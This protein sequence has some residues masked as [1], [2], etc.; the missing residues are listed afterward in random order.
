MAVTW[1]V[2]G[3]ALTI[4]AG[5]DSASAGDTVLV[6]PGTYYETLTMKSGTYVIAEA[7]SPESTVV[8]G[9]EMNAV[10]LFYSHSLTAYLEGFTITNGWSEYGGGIIVIDCNPHITDCRIVDN[11]AFGDGGGIFCDFAAGATFTGCVI[12]GNTCSGNGGA[13]MSKG[14]SNTTLENCTFYANGA[15]GSGVL[16]ID[17]S[18]VDIQNCILSYG[19]SGSAVYCSGTGSATISCSNVYGNVGGDWVDCIAGQNGI[20]GNFSANP[21]FCDAAAGDFHLYETSP[22]VNAPGCGLVGALDVGCRYPK[23]WIVP[24]DAPTIQAG[25]DSTIMADTVLVR[26]GTYHERISVK[27]GISL[28]SETGE[29]DCVTI[30]GDGLGTVVSCW[31][32][33]SDVIYIEGFTITGGAGYTGGGVACSSSR[34][35]M[36]DCI[37]TG[38]T[39]TADGGGISSW[40]S[41]GPLYM[42]RCEITNNYAGD[43]GGGICARYA[44]IGLAYCLVEGNTCA[45]PGGGL[46]TRNDDVNLYKSIVSNNTS[47]SGGGGGHFYDPHTFDCD[48]CTFYGNDAPLASGMFIGDIQYP[49]IDKTIIAFGTGGYAVHGDMVSSILITCSDVYGNEGGDYVQRLAG[50]DTTGNNIW[51]DPLFCDPDSGDFHLANA[52]PCIG[53][54][55]GQIGALGVGC[56][57]PLLRIQSIEDVGDDQGR[58]VRITWR[59]SSY[60]AQTD[61]LDVT[62]YEVYRRQDG[63]LGTGGTQVSPGQIPVLKALGWDYLATVPA[64]GDSYYQYVA[65]T[66]CDSTASGICWSAFFI[67]AATSDPFEYRDSAPDSGYS[68]D[69]LAPTAPPGLIMNSATELAW[70]EV[71]DDDFDYY[72]VYGSALDALDESATLIG[73]TIDLSKDITDHVYEYYH[74]TATDFSGNEGEESSVNNVFAGVPQIRD[75]P[76]AFAL[77][78][79]RPNPFS[80]TTVIGFDLPEETGARIRIYDTH[81]RI[82][83]RLTDSNYEAGRHAVTWRGEDQ[84]GNQVSPGVYFIRMEAGEFEAMKKV[85]LLR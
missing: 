19:T 54:T 47:A 28:I 82:I 34:V 71:P 59:R 74:V 53:G 41:S 49:M 50:K 6:Y 31:F 16:S 4:Q 9:V 36:Y 73:Y 37:I 11:Y 69:N 12:A 70:E 77:R 55:C 76:T 30:D 25:I 57:D 10:V 58:N 63:Q 64:H 8:D 81:G 13:L 56:E 29:A 46:R 62:G 14:V 35:I 68:V 26:C 40:G 44:N 7:G 60:D 78:Q 38:N 52:S 33:H 79:N 84:A 51:A 65:S 32:A 20:N 2:P 80:T 1:E 83:I 42:E 17:S 48:Y 66:L 67:R 39:A 23:T 22:C 24:D 72:S 85:L 21:L 27:P 43:G 15:S 18:S 3:E 75:I 45:G 61:P 5:I